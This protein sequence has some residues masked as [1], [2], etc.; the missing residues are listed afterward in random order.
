M[1][2]PHPERIQPGEQNMS[3]YQTLTNTASM[4]ETVVASKIEKGQAENW[5]LS[6]FVYK[7]CAQESNLWM[8]Q[9]NKQ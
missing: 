8:A 5:A 2:Y 1:Y 7:P 3:D 4:G 9:I 6:S